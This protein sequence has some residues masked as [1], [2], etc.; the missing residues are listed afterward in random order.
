MFKVPMKTVHP[1]LHRLGGLAGGPNFNRQGVVG[2]KVEGY[3]RMI[4]YY[5]N[6][7]AVRVVFPTHCASGHEVVWSIS[8]LV[9]RVEF[10]RSLLSGRSFQWL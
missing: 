2:P 5:F 10:R 4:G 6:P 3:G 7:L 1:S 9:M 8:S